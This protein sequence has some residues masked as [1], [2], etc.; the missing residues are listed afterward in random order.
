MTTEFFAMLPPPGK[1]ALSNYIRSKPNDEQ[2][3]SVPS[4][5]REAMS[6]REAVF[7]HEQ[8]IPLEN[9]LDDD[10]ARCWHW[11][12]YVSVGASSSN[13][14]DSDTGK[15]GRVG[16]TA[17][18]MAAATIRLV[19]PPHS[20]HTTSTSD[21]PAAPPARQHSR[22][23]SS[24]SM[25]EEQYIKLGRLA[26]LAPFR[27]LGL[28][29]LLVDNALTWAAE[30][31]DEIVPRVSATDR[32]AARL[33]AGESDQ[34]AMSKEWDKETWK[35]LVLVHAQKSVQQWW[36]ARGFELDESLG[37]WVEEGIMHVGMWKRI[38]LKSRRPSLGIS[39]PSS[40]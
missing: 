15:R 8:N 2:P 5:F 37:E 27:K 25:E 18:R 16:S 31:A 23:A 12:T 32:E 36:Q 14:A 35:G 19:P 11:V 24:G 39:L 22:H 1:A 34:E 20:A 4:V 10:D 30:H 33:E 13:A 40:H 3:D 17:S 26:T 29:K 28:A 38:A 9:E 21:G 6:V 7:V